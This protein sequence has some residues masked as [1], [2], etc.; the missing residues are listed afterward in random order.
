MARRCSVPAALSYQRQKLTSSVSP[1]S[2]VSDHAISSGTL[3]RRTSITSPL[4]LTMDPIDS[5]IPETKR[6]VRMINRH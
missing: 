4:P 5:L 6:R 3:S 2:M 1:L